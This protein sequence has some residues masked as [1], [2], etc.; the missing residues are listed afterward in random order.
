MRQISLAI[1]A[2]FFLIGCSSANNEEQEMELISILYQCKDG[3]LVAA[4][5]DNTKGD[6]SV[7]LQLNPE[8]PE[9]I[10]LF[11]TRSASGARYSDGKLVWWTKGNAAFLTTA[12]GE[13]NL[14]DDCVEFEKQP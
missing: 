11:L 3:A 5:Y 8:N 13:E 1:I 14:Y 2:F 4:D 6:Q 9:K 12:D 10:R 7:Y